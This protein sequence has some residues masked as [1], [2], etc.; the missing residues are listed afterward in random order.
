MPRRAP[1]LKGSQE[2]VIEDAA[3]RSMARFGQIVESAPSAMVMVDRAGSIELVNAEAER[4]FGYARSELLGRSIEIL[5][6]ERFRG[7]HGELRDAFLS[8]G[9]SRPMGAGREILGL[10]KD[11]SEFPLEIGLNLIETDAGPMVLSAII[12]I[13]ERRRRE[14]AIRSALR[15][16]DVLLGEIHHRVKNN[17]QIIQSLLD[18]QSVKT[19]DR[20]A[21]ELLRE[22]QNRV[23]SMAL[24]HQTLYQS[25]DLARVDFGSFLE[26]LIPALLSSYGV[27]SEHV[28]VV[29]RAGGVT[30]PLDAAVP[31]GLAVNELI[32][33]A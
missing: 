30:L 13:T 5:I 16:K 9:K 7:S 29:T 26:S 28:A 17:L 15:E 32:S 20:V 14:A 21:L 33:N 27:N 19:A 3:A 10:R 31:C 6:P 1:S 22:S 23:R 11:G 25:K 24:I 4:I 18:M 2:I 12:D 8:H